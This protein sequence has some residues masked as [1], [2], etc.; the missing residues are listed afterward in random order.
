MA[1]ITDP[2]DLVQLTEIIIAPG[3]RTIQLLA[4]GNLAGGG[5]TADDNGVTMQALYSF[6]KEEWKDDAT[7]IE[8]PFPMVAISA[9]SG[10]FEFNDDWVLADATSENFIRRGGFSYVST[11]G[12][13]T[14]QF[15]G[16]RSLGVFEDVALDQPYY[17]FGNDPTNL[18]AA[19]DT[20]F[21]GGIDQAL[22]VFD[23]IGNPATCNF[24]TTSTITR[25]AGDFAVDGYV[26]GGQVTIRGSASND[27]TY[28]LTGVVALT[29]TVAA[30]PLTTGLDTNAQL[31]V[32]NRNGVKMFLRV[33]DG[34]TNGKTYATSDVLVDLGESVMSNRL[35]AFGLGN[36]TDLDITATDA[37]IAA[38]SPYT[39]ILVRYLPAA[40]NRAVDDATPGQER[41][42]GIVI[43]VGTYSQSNGASNSNTLFT[44]AAIGEATL[45]DF[46]GGNLII[47]E[48]TDIGT[49]LI[50]GIPVDNGGTLEITLAVGLTA[51]EAGVSF[52]MQRATP[53]VASKTQIYEKVQYLLRQATDID[54]T[55]G[56]VAGDT[57]DALLG[58]VG[59]TLN[60]GAALPTNPNAGG[61]GVI[62]EGFDSNDT[63]SM[64][65]V[66]NVPVEYTFPFVAAGTINFN[67]FLV[68]DTSAVY[69]MFFDY[70]TR[71][72]PSDAQLGLASV[73]GPGGGGFTFADANPDT[74][75]R[76][77]AG[78]WT[79]DGYAEGM[80][81]VVT[82]ANTGAN[83][84]TYEIA[85]LTASTLTLVGTV[86][87]TADV[88]D[89]T[90]VFSPAPSEALLFSALSELPVLVADAYVNVTGF[91]DDMDGIWQAKGTPTAAAAV[92]TR[93]DGAAAV[94]V[95]STAITVDEDP[96]NSPDAIIVNNN[97]GA[98]LTA[99]IAGASIGFDFD[100]DGNVQGG[101]TSATDA[102]VLLRAIGLESGQFVE[103]TGTVTRATGLVFSLV[104]AQERNYSNP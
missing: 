67:S 19:T 24:A 66:D 27:G 48:G 97:A 104:S 90:A 35:F 98:P 94:V 45:A 61:S 86:A 88:A 71:T 81:V 29:L 59:A 91:A 12:V 95:A 99:A 72:S 46:T 18:A 25:S 4:A 80:S 42:F 3:P 36:A 70:T 54:S 89:A 93:Y 28:V 87:L 44:S 8:H 32:D 84:G 1:F 16:F 102:V 79:A 101:R 47:H 96:I 7:L 10:E 43:D 58:F 14:K 78:D 68:A 73:A 53:I 52:T 75:A 92:V 23:E 33:R 76:L 17:V 38:D 85:S 37:S 103:T 2:D 41:A 40:Y 100:Y 49:H 39:E 62:I 57:A 64:T 60:A 74:I 69:W 56:T 50:S 82:L 65:F 15:T 63:N 77:D 83:N 9:N 11:A 20:D 6:L 34:D 5:A 30:A 21:P 51:T 22:K 55:T 26:V 13:L 31:A